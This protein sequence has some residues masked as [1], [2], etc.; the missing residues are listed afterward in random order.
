MKSASD[1][2]RRV[3]VWRVTERCNLGCRFCAYDRHLERSRLHADAAEVLRFGR[4]LAEEA[5][6]V[7]RSQLVSWLGGEPFLWPALVE[8]NEHFRALGFATALTSNG[9]PLA[10]ES[11]RRWALDQLDELTLSI[12]GEA[13]FHDWA[14]DLEGAHAIVFEALRALSRAKRDGRRGPLL[15]VNT[16]LMRDNF[17]RFDALVD[18]LADAGCEEVTFNQLGGNDRPEFFPAHR[19]RVE[20]VEHLAERLPSL[21]ERLRIRG[22]RLRGSP[23]YVHR[24]R[25]SAKAVALPVDDCAPGQDFLFVDER[26]RVAPC[27]FTP[28]GY[29]VPSSE[30]LSAPDIAALPGRFAAAR[31]TRRLAPCLD[32]HSTQVFEKFSAERE[33]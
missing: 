13:S 25:C 18:A 16:I 15:R 33:P 26:G 11:W 30:L 20:Q 3:V 12:D 10:N 21:Q 23:A 7:G 9:L 8:V 5:R 29:G 1:L 31:N 14:R 24:L 27:S 17:D 22:L 4:L 28:S 19:L 32:C 6:I 2:A